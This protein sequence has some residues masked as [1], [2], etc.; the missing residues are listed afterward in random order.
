MAKK[1]RTEVRVAPARDPGRVVRRTFGG[2]GDARAAL[3]VHFSRRAY[4]DVTAHAKESLDAEV[5]GVL[6]GDVCEDDQGLFVDV[7]AVVRGSAAR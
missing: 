3:R 6:V 4:G 1:D 2:P 7:H 5:C